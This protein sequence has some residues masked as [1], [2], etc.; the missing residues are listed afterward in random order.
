[1]GKAIGIDL[2]TT[3]SVGAVVETA[4]EEPTVI[5]MAEGGRLC[6][7]VV[8]FGEGGERLVG[9][10]AKRQATLRPKH[11]VSSVKRLMGRRYDEVEEER[12]IAAY[13]VVSG[14]NGAAVVEVDGKQYTPEEVSSM[15]LE[16]IKADAE[17]FLGEAVTDAVITCPAYFNDSQRQSTKLAGEIAG[18]NVL[19]VINEPTAATLAYG[20]NIDKNQTILV[21]DLGGGT[22]DV[23][24]L[25]MGDGVFEVKSTNGDTHLG[26]D[27]W[28]EML[29]NSLADDFQKENGV[30]LRAD[31]Q[32]LQRLREAAE[33]AKVELST[34]LETSISLPFVT[35][36]Q[37][38]PKHLN[39]T[40]TRNEFEDI[41][42]S[43]TQRQVEPFKNALKDAGLGI[44][45][46]D[47]V[48]LVGGSSRMPAVQ[49]LVK[50]LTGK[51]PNKTVNPDE[52]VGAGAA[53]QAAILTGEGGGRDIVL[54]DVTPLSLGVETAGGVMTAMIPRNTAIPTDAT[55]VYTTAK[56]MQTEVEV[57]VLQGERP[58]ARDNRSLGR[59]QLGGIPP[60]P[61]GQP[62]VE[63]TFALD[64]N[65]ILSVSAKERATGAEQKVTIAGS[66]GLSK[67][68]V[69]KI[70]SDAESHAD[71]DQKRQ[72]LIETRHSAGQ[73][74]SQANRLLEEHASLIPESDQERV[75]AGVAKVRGLETSED[76][77]A[78][79]SAQAEL[80]EAYRAAGDAIYQQSQAQQAAAAA[81]AAAE[82]AEP[83]EEGSEEAPAE[84]AEE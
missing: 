42:H 35:A 15:I 45:G 36:D 26:G 84:E 3:N 10:L 68:D 4:G 79:K 58:M 7:S 22:F 31:A 63:V 37:T 69:E 17:A 57:H 43:L 8:G 61:K 50:E 44:D 19:R 28:D 77:D 55:E 25:E 81:E 38:G 39:V 5:T 16:K 14:K 29:V 27:N 47:E 40:L 73:L 18:F 75:K 20:I 13:D 60:A 2:G 56:D 59:F 83:A 54:V 53:I 21:W 30:D 24:V 9:V 82:A 80:E 12:K 48:V 23:T 52:V 6:P 1:M 34:V 70:V 67:A 71:E 72:E 32:A 62:Q 46:L 78:I 76:L 74:A 66:T 49:A 33:K 64:A 51:E 65:G 41:T 11:T